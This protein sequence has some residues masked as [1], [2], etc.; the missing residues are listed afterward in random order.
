MQ[1]VLCHV[2]HVNNTLLQLQYE[3]DCAEQNVQDCEAY[4]DFILGSGYNGHFWDEP[5]G[6]P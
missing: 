1:H 6:P 3:Q 5:D 2:H 4:S